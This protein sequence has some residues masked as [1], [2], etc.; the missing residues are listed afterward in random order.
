MTTRHNS[1]ETT[2]TRFF[3]ARAVCEFDPR[4][5]AA[6]RRCAKQMC[7][8]IGIEDCEGGTYV[9]TH[10]TAQRTSANNNALL[11]ICENQARHVIEETADVI[12]IE[13]P[14]TRSSHPVNA[15]PNQPHLSLT[16]SHETTSC[17]SQTCSTWTRYD[18][19]YNRYV[20]ANATN[21]TRFQLYYVVIRPRRTTC[22]GDDTPVSLTDPR[23]ELWSRDVKR[24]SARAIAFLRG[25]ESIPDVIRCCVFR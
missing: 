21:P 14:P 16:I 12:T 8:K 23:L 24:R 9:N 13:F 2:T 22:R 5:E 6:T 17:C 7:K 4:E 11:A 25:S 15:A 19:G 18:G 3:A 10:N 1:S 20:V